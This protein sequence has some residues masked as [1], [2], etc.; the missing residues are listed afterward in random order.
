MKVY[1]I[2][3]PYLTLY[4]IIYVNLCIFSVHFDRLTQGSVLDLPL[5]WQEQIW[6]LNKVISVWVLYP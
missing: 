5:S 3:L 1:Q 2:I 4:L 6:H